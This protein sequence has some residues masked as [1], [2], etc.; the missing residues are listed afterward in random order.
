MI[1]TALLKDR[2]Q[3]EATLGRSDLGTTYLARDTATRR[4]V[5]V[6]ELSLRQVDKDKAVELFQR[7]ARVLARLEHPRIP[8]FIELFSLETAEEV[9]LYLVQQYIE[10]KNLAQLVKAGKHF[11]EREAIQM[12]LRLARILEHLHRLSPPVIHRDIKPTNVLLDSAG[13]PYLIDFGAVREILLH[14]ELRAAG[15][16]VAG[17]YGYMPFEQFEGQALPASDLYSLGATLLFLLSHKDPHQMESSPGT[18]DFRPHLNV[19]EGFAEVLAKTVRPAWEDRYQNASELAVALETL[20]AG[21]R[22][23]KASRWRRV[24]LTGLAALLIAGVLGGAGYWAYDRLYFGKSLRGHKASVDGLAFSGDGKYLA[25]SSDSETLVWDARSGRKLQAL[26][27]RI[28]STQINARAPIAFSPDGQHLASA[29]IIWG[30]VPQDNNDRVLIWDVASGEIVRRFTGPRITVDSLAYAPDAKVLAVASNTWLEDEKYFHDGQIE[31]WEV[32]S[33][34]RLWTLRRNHSPI[35]S[36]T[37]SP[38]G[39]YL[40]FTSRRFNP[41]QRWFDEGEIVL[42]DALSGAEMSSFPGGTDPPQYLVFSPDGTR[43]A[44]SYD[45]CQK[46]TVWSLEGKPISLLN[47]EADLLGYRA[48]TG[49]AFSPDGRFF[50]APARAKI[51][52]SEKPRDEIRVWRTSTWRPVVNFSLRSPIKNY[53]LD[54][55]A[56]SPDGRTVVAGVGN[57]FDGEVKLWRFSPPE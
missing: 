56:F 5:V 31:F 35:H 33:G 53:A 24:L 26:A 1:S 3:I 45:S 9:Q 12:G 19:S 57:S 13:E 50:A 32:E 6:K 29:Q 54:S 10:G 18:L 21:K 42:H 4:P 8:R 25:S 49:G 2:Y 36:V 55:V 17:T 44:A 51:P 43:I 15:R 38:D 16:T 23:A 22:P 40:A 11:S 52:S 28:G 41:Q 37:F 48:F 20:L 7:E 47:Q 39:H 14:S 30:A 46:V 34:R 27:E